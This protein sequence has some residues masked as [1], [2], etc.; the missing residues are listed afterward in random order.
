MEHTDEFAYVNIF[1][2]ILDFDNTSGG[3]GSNNGENKIIWYNK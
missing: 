3:N 2:D 1:D